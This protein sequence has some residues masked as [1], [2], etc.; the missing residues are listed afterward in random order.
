MCSIVHHLFRRSSS[1][2]ARNPHLPAPQEIVA[3][4]ESY[5]REMLRTVGIAIGVAFALLG[6]QAVIAGATHLGSPGFSGAT[7]PYPG[8]ALSAAAAALAVLLPSSIALQILLRLPRDPDQLAR[9]DAVAQRQFWGSVAGLV[10]AG[11]AFVAIGAF[12]DGFIAT[13]NGPTLDLNRLFGIPL[14]SAIA[15][16]FAADAAA[17]AQR[18]GQKLRLADAYRGAEITALKIAIARVPGGEN[19]TPRRRLVRWEA[20]AILMSTGICT[21]AAWF[22]VQDARATAVYAITTIM[23]S[24]FAALALPRTAI[25]ALRG[26]PLEVIMQTLLPGLVII[27]YALQLTAFA[28][29]LIDD[30]E[31]P[32]AYVPSIAYGLLVFLPVVSFAVAVAVRVPG[33]SLAAPLLDYARFTMRTTANRLRSRRTERSERETWE[34]F[35][36]AA[37]GTCLIPIISIPLAAVATLHRPSIKLP[38][39]RL[40]A[41]MWILPAAVAAV[42]IVAL[43]LL[44]VYSV[45]FGWL[46]S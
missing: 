7:V 35:A 45:A 32:W 26:R 6:G 43:L 24:L 11:A 4:G 31:E 25:G 28:F 22:I 5:S 30:Q 20:T 23:V 15:V 16:A 14:G 44:P 40:F 9:G 36:Y 41:V 12:I 19:E 34:I 3:A 1:L 2:D 37:L 46:P 42:E 13:M 29:T 21:A 10:S 38:R 27:V 8:I 18:E 17:T 39:R 33:S